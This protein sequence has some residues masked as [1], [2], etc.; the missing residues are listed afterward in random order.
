MP[1]SRA[2]RSSIHRAVSAVTVTAL[3]ALGAV[4]GGTAAAMAAADDPPPDSWMMRLDPWPFPEPEPPADV[5]GSGYVWNDRASASGPYYAHATYSNN[6]TGGQNQIYRS[7]A[8]EYTVW[9]P[10]LRATGVAHVT[11]YAD[12]DIRCAV[13]AR[14]AY[15][16][17]PG[18]DVLVRCRGAG[19]QLVDSTFTVSYLVAGDGVSTTKDADVDGAYVLANPVG[20]P[21]PVDQYNSRGGVNKVERIYPGLYRVVLPGLGAVAG[22]VQVT[23]YGGGGQW[24]S[25]MSWGPDDGAQHVYV[26]CFADDGR[27]ADSPFTLTYVRDTSLLLGAEPSAYAWADRPTASKYSPHPAYAYDT[28]PAAA[29]EIERYGTGTYAV[30]PPVPLNRGHV[31]V[32]AYGSAARCTVVFWYPYYGVRVNCFG[33]DGG[34]VDSMYDVAV[35]SRPVAAHPG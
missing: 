31:Q 4:I 20:V 14:R 9:F 13:W 23:A 8:G 33:P 5:D 7:G 16:R 2:A 6:S 19:G 24:C 18:T 17:G 28:D 25:P 11:A 26:R 21:I 12:S 29:I 32:T 27:P 1:N 34:R 35:V 30:Y 22:H 3:V 15:T 10:Y